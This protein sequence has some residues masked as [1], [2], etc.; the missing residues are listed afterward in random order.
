[1]PVNQSPSQR[2]HTSKPHPTSRGGSGPFTGGC[3]GRAKRASNVAY[4]SSIASQCA[5]RDYANTSRPVRS[6]GI[7]RGSSPIVR[8]AM[9]Y[10]FTLPDLGE[11]LTEGDIARWLVTEGD[12]IAEDLP[13][14][15]I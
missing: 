15:E 14:V 2:A 10:E 4:A 5:A 11:G 3:S 1:M 12:E 9:A 13:L 8:S 6:R 7:V